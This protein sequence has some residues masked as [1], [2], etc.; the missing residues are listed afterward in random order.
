MIFSRRGI[1]PDIDK[2]KLFIDNVELERLGSDCRVKY[3]KFVGYLIEDDLKW[4]SH[5]NQ[6]I[7]NYPS[8]ITP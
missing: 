5:V 4:S 2:C 3:F 8:Q 1:P 6:L 7:K